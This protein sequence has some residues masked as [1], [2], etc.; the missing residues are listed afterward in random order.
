MC[1]GMDT[2]TALE[3]GFTGLNTRAGALMNK[4]FKYMPA[5]IAGGEPT[6][7]ADRMQID[8]HSDHIL[9]SPRYRRK[10]FCRYVMVTY[11]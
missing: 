9:D 8:L 4:Q 10:S 7:V 1:L 6:C 5:V 2:E 11:T 3:A